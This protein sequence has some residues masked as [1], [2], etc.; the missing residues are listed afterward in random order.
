MTI[1]F[2]NTYLWELYDTGRT[3]DRKH[4]FQPEIVK[5]YRKTI[6]FLAIAKQVTDLFNFSGLNYEVLHG[7]KEGRS[8]VRINAKYRLEFTV[9]TVEG[10]EIVTICTVLDITNHYQ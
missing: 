1:E 4:R 10:E 9:K 6:M 8:S 2:D 5:A 3:S 7:D